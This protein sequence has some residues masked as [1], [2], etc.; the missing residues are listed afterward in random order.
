MPTETSPPGNRPSTYTLLLF[1]KPIRNYLFRAS[2]SQ[3]RFSTAREK[4]MGPVD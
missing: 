1:N 4:T 3:W 2:F